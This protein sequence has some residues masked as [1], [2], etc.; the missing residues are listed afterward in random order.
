MNLDF[1]KQKL[2][3]LQG[4][5]KQSSKFWKPTEGEHKVRI[6]PYKYNKE[7][8]FQELKF[9]YFRQSN[10]VTKTLLSPAINGN[11]DPVLEFCEKLRG[12]GTKE[13]WVLSKSYE[14]KLRTYVPVIVRGKEEEGVK[15]W[16]FGKQVYE[17]ILE[18]MSNPD[19]GDITDLV[20]GNDLIVKFT[21]NPPSGK[22][23]PETKIDVRI[24]KTPAVD[25]A[26]QELTAKVLDQVDIMTL[27]TEPTYDELKKEFENN[28]NPENEPTPEAESSETT[29]DGTP[30][31]TAPQND[32][33]T[34]QTGATGA[35]AQETPATP[36][37]ASVT[38]EKSVTLS[39]DEMKAKF[40]KMFA[41]AA[42]SK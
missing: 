30:D 27:F 24:K 33:A 26:N 5:N 41:E 37:D 16:G 8:P 23:F 11:P 19:I 31:E 40:K 6:L 13:N 39:P 21:K 14:P 38:T 22:K 12:T 42:A 15:F 17:A 1:I 36:T 34:P 3:T 4:K 9:Y 28:L 2:D 18:K 29:G 7:N 20:E 32:A 10:G 25:P 35:T